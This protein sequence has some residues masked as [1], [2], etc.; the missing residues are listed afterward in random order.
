MSEF[1]PE[2]KWTDFAKLVKDRQVS[3]LKSCEVTFNGEH[4]FT[5]IIPHGDMSTKDYARTQA[6]YLGMR[7][8]IAGG[9][10]VEELDGV[11]RIPV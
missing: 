1:I 10:D 2:V 9:K 4:L 11:A 7:S 3:E 8:N 5:A 6:E